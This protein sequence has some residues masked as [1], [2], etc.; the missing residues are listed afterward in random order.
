M[1]LGDP[2]ACLR[3]NRDADPQR[4]RTLG[5]IHAVRGLIE[6]KPFSCADLCIFRSKPAT[7][8]AAKWATRSRANWSRHS[9]VMWA[10]DSA[11]NCATFST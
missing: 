10:T 2:L 3:E 4:E 6:D 8:S 7:D 9:A 5:F 1:P 11:V